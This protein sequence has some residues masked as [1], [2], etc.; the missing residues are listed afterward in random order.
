MKIRHLCLLTLTLLAAAPL[1]AQ[2]TKAG[3]GSTRDERRAKG[4]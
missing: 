2:G 3:R 4:D 1:A